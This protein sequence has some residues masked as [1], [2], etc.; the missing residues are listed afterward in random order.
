VAKKKN[1]KP[2]TR[3]QKTHKRWEVLQHRERAFGEVQAANVLTNEALDRKREQLNE[4]SA[5]VARALL[6]DN[7]RGKLTTHGA[8]LLATV[9]NE[10]AEPVYED[11]AITTSSYEAA[12]NRVRETK[13]KAVRRKEIDT[14]QLAQVFWLQAKRMVRERREREQAR[15]EKEQ[16]KMEFEAPQAKPEPTPPQ[17]DP[18][19]VAK[20]RK[21]LED[22]RQQLSQLGINPDDVSPQPPAPENDAPQ[23]P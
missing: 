6:D 17:P 1:D 7:K 16:V 22:A 4:E 21:Q 23:A 11:D 5:S 19:A 15:L 3:N 12:G 9:L 13:V 2:L 14:E 18:V 10:N 20:L 8:E